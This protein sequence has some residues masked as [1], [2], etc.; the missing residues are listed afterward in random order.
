MSVLQVL[1]RSVP[2]GVCV[3]RFAKCKSN[4]VGKFSRLQFFFSY[5]TNFFRILFSCDKMVARETFAHKLVLV[6]RVVLS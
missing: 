1:I 4:I 2:L 3:D 5:F 6:F